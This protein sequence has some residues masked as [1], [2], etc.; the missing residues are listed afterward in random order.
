MGVCW[1]AVRGLLGCCWGAVG[2]PASP[3]ST[4]AWASP[5]SGPQAHADRPVA[6]LSDNHPP[7]TKGPLLRFLWPDSIFPADGQTGGGG[8]GKTWV[9]GPEKLAVTGSGLCS[10]P[11]GSQG[12][13][14]GGGA[15]REGPITRVCLVL[16]DTWLPT[17]VWCAQASRVRYLC[18]F[19]R[20]GGLER[21]V[22]GAELLFV[23]ISGQS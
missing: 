10:R 11:S 15:G 9:A 2:G 19:D 4:W 17:P 22:G 3:M 12:G 23:V 16:D 5:I 14:G 7:L 8:V 1:G 20:R 13:G 18:P 21:Q 6:Q